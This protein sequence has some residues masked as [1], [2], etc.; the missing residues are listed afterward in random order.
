MAQKPLK[1]FK[2]NFSWIME[3][4]PNSIIK[5]CSQETCED[6]FKPGAYESLYTLVRHEQV[7]IMKK[8]TTIAV[9]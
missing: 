8:R 9:L 3:S 6:I 2:D 5:Q 7:G 1:H 4:T